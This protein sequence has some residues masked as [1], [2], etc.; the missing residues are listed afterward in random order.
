[1]TSATGYE[2]GGVTPRANENFGYGYD[3]AGNLLL[4]TNNTLIQEF[5][6]DN[7]NEVVNVQRNNN[8]LTV[9]GSLNGPVASLAINGQ[10][11]AVYGDTTYAVPGGLVVTNGLNTLTAVVNG[12]Q[13]NQ[14]G[15]C[16]PVGVSLQYDLNGNLIS[17]GQRTY[18]YDCANELVQ[19]VATNVFSASSTTTNSCMT[20][21]AYDGFGRRRVRQDY[22]WGPISAQ[23]GTTSGWVKL[24][25]VRYIYD[26]MTVLQ[27]RDVNNNVL[28][29]YTR[30][31][32]LSGTLQGAGGVG[33]LLAR[34]DNTGNSAYY[35][36][37]GNGNVTMLVDGSGNLLAKY[38]YDSFGN[39]LGMW[40]P[41]AETNTYRFSS[42]E[43][44]L[45]SGLYYFGYRYYQPNLQRWLN[46]DPIGERGGLNLYRF[47]RNDPINLF[48]PLGL[49]DYSAQETQQQFL[50][51]A[52]DSATA[53]PIQGIINM[54]NNS[55]GAGPYDFAFNAHKDDTFC[56]N[57]KRMT[58]AGF[59]NFMAGYQGKS[60]DNWVTGSPFPALATMYAAGWWYHNTPDNSTSQNDPLDKSGFPYIHMGAQ[61]APTPPPSHQDWSW[62]AS[63]GSF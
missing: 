10:A 43:V 61:A 24:Y 34:T 62:A 36:A 54:Y 4:R 21:Y 45:T 29:T 55:S 27:E 40:G 60:Y 5:T 20:K 52:F 28:V 49:Y 57:G 44:D 59:A 6:L 53:G 58:A 15:E 3:L 18:A 37:D 56:V 2:P 48:D 17:D 1:L 12:T 33:G 8:L 41:L 50:G 47:V 14:V 13:T 35:H 23:S 16:L 30:G 46:R 39:T 22:T 19:V 42:K 26:G 11:A 32:D 25:E 9:A 63:G 7:A 51:P 31:L 38:L